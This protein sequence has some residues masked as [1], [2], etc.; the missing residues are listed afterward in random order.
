MYYAG[1]PYPC[2]VWGV[3]EAWELPPPMTLCLGGRSPDYLSPIAC[4]TRSYN[5]GLTQNPARV[6]QSSRTGLRSGTQGLVLGL[7]QHAKDAHHIEPQPACH[8]PDTPLIDQH[9]ICLK[10]HRQGKRCG[11][12]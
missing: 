3:E 2:Q 12:P 5:R 7:D 11:S 4:K 1:N 10:F 9:H 8:Y 6:I